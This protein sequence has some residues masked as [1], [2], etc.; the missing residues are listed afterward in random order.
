MLMSLF[1]I[2]MIIWY[3]NTSRSSIDLMNSIFT[4][5]L[6]KYFGLPANTVCS[7]IYFLSDT[8]PLNMTLKPKASTAKTKIDNM[9]RVTM[10]TCDQDIVS[11]TGSIAILNSMKQPTSRLTKDVNGQ[12]I[13]NWL[14][15]KISKIPCYF[16]RSKTIES[17]P[18]QQIKRKKLRGEITDLRHY[19]FC[20]RKDFHLIQDRRQ[21]YLHLL[22]RASRTLSLTFLIIPFQN[23][24]SNF[25]FQCVTFI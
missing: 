13:S 12:E 25:E 4:K 15:E 10:S 14:L 19:T 24:S 8:K 23:I 20:D 11:N 1:F 16:W 7:I 3:E 9:L 21:M 5:Y 22:Q 17:F 6:K 18:T 2:I